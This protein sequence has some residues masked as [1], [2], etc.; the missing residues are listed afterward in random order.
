MA[1]SPGLRLG[2]RIGTSLPSTPISIKV[3]TPEVKA[4]ALTWRN[5]EIATRAL[6]RDGLVVLEDVI[7]EAALDRLNEKMV[8]DAYRLQ[9]RGDDAPFN[10]NKGNIQQDPPLLR[11]WWEPQI[12]I[13]PIVTQVTSTT[14]GRNPR[15]S[16]ISGN[17]ALPP[18]P[19]SPPSAQPTHTD[20]DFD[21]PNIPFALV[22]NI[23]L[24][25]M[26]PENGSTEVWLGTQDF[27]GL[28]AQEGRHGERASGRIKGYLKERR[29][30]ER[31]PVQPVVGKGAVVLRDLRL[32][33]GGMTNLTGDP[34]VM[35]A[36]IHFAPWY[37]NRMAV[38][39]SKELEPELSVEKTGLQVQGVFLGEDEVEERYLNRPFGN[40]YDFSQQEPIEGLF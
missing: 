14:L 28:N 39:F 29:L 22:A 12:F 15:L 33:Q 21:H 26:T 23:P 31:P 3:T 17:T 40:A 38:E 18:T 11:K 1:D 7:P 20:A 19:S 35:L 37:R 6:R 34:R 10:Y 27:A 13:N 5:L 16:F 32:W 30:E 2:F 25:T 24:V 8:E 36:M 9:R 4:G